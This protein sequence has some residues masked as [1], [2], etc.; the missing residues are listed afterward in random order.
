MARVPAG[1]CCLLALAGLD[2]GIASRHWLAD[3]TGGDLVTGLVQSH[4]HGGTWWNL[5]Y[6]QVAQHDMQQSGVSELAFAASGIVTLVLA[7]LAG[8][9][10]AIATGVVA[11]SPRG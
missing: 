8:L 1:I 9:L 10:L 3:T 5:A 11:S 4:A 7:A 2:I 6:V